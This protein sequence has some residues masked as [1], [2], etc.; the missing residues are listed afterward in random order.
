MTNNNRKNLALVAVLASLL[1]GCNVPSIT[2]NVPKEVATSI[3]NLQ[4]G[5]A[6]AV[7]EEPAASTTQRT[8]IAAEPEAEVVVPHIEGAGHVGPTPKPSSK[9]VVTNPTPAPGRAAGAD[10]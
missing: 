10:N 5:V 8:A 4:Q 3:D 6:P 2:V 9:P 1:M 7:T